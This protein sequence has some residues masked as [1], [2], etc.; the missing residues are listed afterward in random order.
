M[1]RS[2]SRLLR[3][4]ILFVLLV[5]PTSAWAQPRWLTDAASDT[6]AFLEHKSATSIL[7]FEARDIKID[8]DGHART[9]VR[10]ARKVLTGKAVSSR[11]GYLMDFETEGLSVRNIR[12][13]KIGRDGVPEELEDEQIV[14]ISP[15]GMEA[16]FSHS[17]YVIGGFAEV[18]FGDVVGFE[19]DIEDREPYATYQ[20]H[21]FQTQEPVRHTALTLTVPRGWT[22]RASAWN[23]DSIR[24]E[25][26]GTVYSWV[27]RDLPYRPEE[28]M[29]PS[30]SFLERELRLTISGPPG[31]RTATMH[32]SDWATVSE[33]AAAFNDAAVERTP[34]IRAL[35]DSLT[36]GSATPFEK[37]RS[38]A[39]WV[40]SRVRYVAVEIGPGRWE[41]H[42]SSSILANG[43]GD[44]KDKVALFRSLLAEAGIPSAAVLAN[45][46]SYVD[47]TVP[48]LFQFNHVIAA[49]PDSVAGGGREM[50]SIGAKG[51]V[52]FDPTDPAQPFGM[53]PPAL[54]GN[55]ALVLAGERGGI[56]R[57]PYGDPDIYRRYRRA[58]ITLSYPDTL[59]AQITMGA[60]GPIAHYMRYYAALTPEKD[61]VESVRSEYSRRFRSFQVSD[62]T[63]SS[64]GDTAWTGFLLTVPGAFRESG[65]KIFLK[66]NLFPLEWISP[67]TSPARSYPVWFGGPEVIETELSCDP[68]ERWAP[69]ALPQG[70]VDSCLGAASLGYSVSAEGRAL[71]I[72]SAYSCGGTLTDAEQ[73]VH[74]KK[75]SRS[76]QNFNDLTITLQRKK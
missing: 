30:W 31:T 66:A 61:R 38:I 68:G 7:L 29:M 59:R 71:R 8:D 25:Q 3:A 40:Q 19:Y 23:L 33:R 75:F 4:A 9:H 39:S 43:Y 58:R 41:P 76:V 13:W 37:I 57:V 63:T 62:Y 18:A 65:G 27:G 16:I 6:V 69:A 12:G 52:F 34:G 72:T 44:C 56:V 17:Q 26:A 35:A 36:A 1:A 73:Y 14:R 42:N 5:P 2:S 10:L 50:E 24:Y 15:P 28:P 46:E 21:V 55:R 54:R 60:I 74:A 51:W 64:S 70:A 20:R 47:S 67:L 11:D 48:S 32:P 53:L 45:T 49:I 22:V